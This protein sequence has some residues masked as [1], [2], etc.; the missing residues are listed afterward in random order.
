MA[1]VLNGRMQ[2]S[3]ISAIRFSEREQEERGENLHFTFEA[4]RNEEPWSER[5]Q[6][7]FPTG[8]TGSQS[9]K[10]EE[11]Q[12]RPA[13][14]GTIPGSRR[15]W[16]GN[17]PMAEPSSGKTSLRGVLARSKRTRLGAGHLEL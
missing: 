9:V 16:V 5:A 12:V 2:F 17:D 8:A 10:R 13:S 7:V 15:L 11:N 14:N 3:P 6:C 1:P 4:G